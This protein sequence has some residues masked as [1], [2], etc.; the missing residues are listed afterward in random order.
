MKGGLYPEGARLKAL[1]LPVLTAAS[2]FS[3]NFF[4]I[5][6]SGFEQCG[7][8]THFGLIQD[9]VRAFSEGFKTWHPHIYAIIFHHLSNVYA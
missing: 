3:C 6:T 5:L 8:S 2:D 1:D 7:G 4:R 9:Q